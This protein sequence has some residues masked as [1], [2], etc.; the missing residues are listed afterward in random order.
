[1]ETC[2]ISCFLVNSF[3]TSNGIETLALCGSMWFNMNS[4]ARFSSFN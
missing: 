2:W 1:M 3:F 4:W